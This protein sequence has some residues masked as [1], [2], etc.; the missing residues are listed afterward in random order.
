ML[1]YYLGRFHGFIADK[2]KYALNPY[3]LVGICSS[4]QECEPVMALLFVDY[5]HRLP[6]L[7]P[8]NPSIT[9]INA[10]NSRRCGQPN[11]RTENANS[12]G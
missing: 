11:A 4:L 1:A 10:A 3:T 6:S 9:F 8:L 12:L 5:A 2:M 7:V